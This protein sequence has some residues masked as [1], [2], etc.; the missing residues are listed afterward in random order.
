VRKTREL[1]NGSV[2]RSYDLGDGL[3]MRLLR[4]AN[5]VFRGPLLAGETPVATVALGIFGDGTTIFDLAYADD[6]TNPRRVGWGVPPQEPV[7]TPNPRP[8]WRVETLA[9]ATAGFGD[10]NGTTARFNS[11]RQLVASQQVPGRY[12]ACDSG[13]HRIVQLDRTLTGLTT[14]TLVGNGT[15]GDSN[16]DATVA[17]FRNPTGLAVAADDTLYVSELQGNRIRRVSSTNSTPSVDTLAGDVT[18]DFVDGPGSAARF[19]A[20]TGLLL[21]EDVLFI[22]DQGNHA[23]RALNLGMP[24]FPVTTVIG[25]RVAGDADGPAASV[26]LR[27]P[28]ALALA[29]DGS[30]WMTE[31]NT[32]GRVR[33][34]DPV[35]GQVT[36]LVAGV[37]EPLAWRDG[38]AGDCGLFRPVGLFP[39]GARGTFATHMDIRSISAD[40]SIRSIA[41][42]SMEQGGQDGVENVASFVAIWGLI[43]MPDG[44]YLLT[45]SSRIRRLIPPVP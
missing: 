22:A 25:D 2:T 14:T 21:L 40:G 35:A 11:L 32:S 6:P 7:P 34:Y 39:L 17:R 12:F 19:T 3:V 29:A 28:I 45:D 18:A 36:T 41:G 1:N 27:Q 5:N 20:P 33:R 37:P 9:G 13:N 10:G 42:R 31:A 38:P 30:I 44:S 23:L 4:G 16:G 43:E 24:N 26:R 8:A 15:A